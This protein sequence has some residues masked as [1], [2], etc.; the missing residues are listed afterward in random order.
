MVINIICM[1]QSLNNVVQIRHMLALD[2]GA[3]VINYAVYNTL[4]FFRLN[5][6]MNEYEKRKQKWIKK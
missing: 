6:I 1:D 2:F 3:D 4:D 5:T